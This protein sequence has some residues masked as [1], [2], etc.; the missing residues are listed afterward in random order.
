MKEYNLH[1]FDRITYLAYNGFGRAE[2]II[3]SQ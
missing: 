3:F 2:I 1:T